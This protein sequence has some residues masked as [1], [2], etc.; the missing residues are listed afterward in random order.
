MHP[1]QFKD[2][3]YRKSSFTGK[4]R[5]ACVEVAMRQGVVGVRST[6]DPQK[7]TVY[8]TAEEWL[9]FIAGVKNGEFDPCA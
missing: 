9:A 4:D 3:E 8:Y 7:V 1:V 2:N 6:T 5:W